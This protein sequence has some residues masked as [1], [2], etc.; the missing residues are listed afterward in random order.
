MCAA[1]L[2]QPLAPC[3]RCSETLGGPLIPSIGLQVPKTN[4]L[5]LCVV[6]FLRDAV[7]TTHGEQPTCPKVRHLLIMVPELER[8]PWCLGDKNWLEKTGYI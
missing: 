7:I 2:W 5:G 8:C 4:F 3:G 1:E 6:N